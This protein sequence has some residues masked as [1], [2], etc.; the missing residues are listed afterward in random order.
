MGQSYFYS[1]G[2]GGNLFKGDVQTWNYRPG[3]AQIKTILPSLNGSFGVQVNK[4]FDFRAQLNVGY[5]Q[6]NASLRPSPAISLSSFYSPP[7]FTSPLIQLSV[8]ADYNFF[9][10]KSNEETWFSWTPYFV[11][12]IG[13]FYG[14]PRYGNLTPK[15]V[16][17]IAIP[18]G[19]GIK[20]KLNKN[21]MFRFEAL[22]NKLTT[23]KLDWVSDQDTNLDILANDPTN[24]K[25][26]KTDQYFNLSFS[27]I[28]SIYPIICPSSY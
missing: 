24:F 3:F 14:N 9:D 23:D 8:L 1:L 13:A 26:S 6:G 19:V 4:T 5:I 7:V 22:A 16:I 17:S 28:Y 11:G 20:W 12:G 10:F 25:L 27:V 15:P 18:Y 2:I 21:V